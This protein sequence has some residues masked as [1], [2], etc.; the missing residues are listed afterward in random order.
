MC[1]LPDSNHSPLLCFQLDKRFCE[2]PDKDVGGQDRMLPFPQ[3]K[4]SS[5]TLRDWFRTVSACAEQDYG[6][7]KH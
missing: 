5:R 3:T 4:S 1:Q 6:S 2:G 7:I